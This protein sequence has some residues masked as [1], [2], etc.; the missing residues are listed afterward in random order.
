MLCF[1]R[2]YECL[3]AYI[4]NMFNNHVRNTSFNVSNYK[5][6]GSE[7]LML[8]VID[9]FS[10]GRIKVSC[11]KNKILN[12]NNSTSILLYMYKCEL[13]YKPRISHV[14]IN[15]IW[16]E[17]LNMCRSLGP[18]WAVASEENELR[19][20]PNIQLQSC[21]VRKYHKRLHWQNT[22][23]LENMIEVNIQ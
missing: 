9:I 6:R 23:L 8:S 12:T 11:W 22:A 13:K 19:M 1:S 20:Y 18:L 7:N 4:I 3:T 14:V 21:Y 10:K 2:N 15:S 16:W 17:W 5:M